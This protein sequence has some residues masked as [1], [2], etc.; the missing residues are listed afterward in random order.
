MASKLIG[1]QMT[2]AQSALKAKG[3]TLDELAEVTNEPR[4]FC[5]DVLLGRGVHR[6]NRNAQ[7]KV[8]KIVAEAVG[9][10][11]EGLFLVSDK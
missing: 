9:L 4:S 3:I 1:K 7:R 6:R 5:R 10:T 11:V 2:L 8:R